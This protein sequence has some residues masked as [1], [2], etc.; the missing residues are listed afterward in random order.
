MIEVLANALPTDRPFISFQFPGFFSVDNSRRLL[1]D[2]FVPS[3][4]GARAATSNAS[5]DAGSSDAEAEAEA[6]KSRPAVSV[7][8][9]LS[10][11]AVFGDEEAAPL[12]GVADAASSI[13]APAKNVNEEEEEEKAELSY[14]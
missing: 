6:G 14:K 5:A 12:P 7:R 13:F 9:D 11:G 10:R 2:P 4:S 1:K 3:L 8:E